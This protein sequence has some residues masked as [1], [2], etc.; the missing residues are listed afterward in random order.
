MLERSSRLSEVMERPNC[1]VDK[2]ERQDLITPWCRE[3]LG[4]FIRRP[5]QALGPP[6]RIGKLRDRQQRQV[7]GLRAHRRHRR[8]EAARRHS[9]L[10]V[11]LVLCEHLNRVDPW[12]GINDLV[13]YTAEESEVLDRIHVSRY[14]RRLGA[15]SLPAYPQQVSALPQRHWLL[16]RRHLPGPAIAPARHGPLPPAHTAHPAAYP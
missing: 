10:M 8:P 15:R 16:A 14:R 13:T 5:E 12:I 9:R 4:N 7:N 1:S 2:D 6:H 3:V 11:G